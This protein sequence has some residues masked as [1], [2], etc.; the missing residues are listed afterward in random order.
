LVND[1]LIKAV[2]I[3]MRDHPRPNSPLSGEQV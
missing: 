2:A 1:L 3:T